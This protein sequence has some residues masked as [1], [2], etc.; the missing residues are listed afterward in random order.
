MAD[1]RDILNAHA[2]YMYGQLL[3]LGAE[4]FDVSPH[5]EAFFGHFD[6]VLPPQGAYIL[7]HDENGKVVGTGALL[8]TSQETAEMKHLY[9][10]PEARKWGLGHSLISARLEA[11][12]KLGITQV[13]AETFLTNEPMMRLYRRLGFTETD[14]FGAAGTTITPGLAPFARSFQIRI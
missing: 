4:P 11:A 2:E 8:R 7:A 1:A 14:P 9:V 10:R 3:G 13:F 6:R 12:K 5:I